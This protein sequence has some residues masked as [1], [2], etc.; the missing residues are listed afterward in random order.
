MVAKIIIQAFFDFETELYRTVVLAL[1]CARFYF[2]GD[3]A[4]VV[5]NF[6]RTASVASETP[7]LS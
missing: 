4:T 3:E 5:F 2:F 6:G 1:V 7:H